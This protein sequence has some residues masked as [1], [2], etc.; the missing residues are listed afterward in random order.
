MT[1]IKWD[2]S[3]NEILTN[4]NDPDWYDYE[5][6]KWANAK[7][8]D[9]SYWVWIPRYAYKITSGYHSSETGTIDIK[10]LKGTSNETEDETK[11]E[12]S[13]YKVG[14]KDTSMHYF[15]HPAFEFNEAD[16]GFW[17]AKY[18]PTA[19]E[20]VASGV[21]EC[22]SLDNVTTKTVK[23][24]PNTTSWRCITIAKAYNVSFDMKNK[25]EIYGWL[26]AELDSH[27]IKNSEWG[28]VDYLSKSKYGAE[29][30]KI[31]NN[32]YNQYQTGCSG[33]GVNAADESICI[34]YNTENGVKAS[35][36]H[37]IYGIY[38]MSGGAYERIM[39]NY[40]NLPEWSGF[41]TTIIS[42]MNSKYINKYNTLTDNMLN[43]IGMD[44]DPNNYGDAVYETSNGA[45]RCDSYYCSTWVGNKY[46]SW[47]NNVSYLSH[48]YGPWAKRGGHFSY[49]PSA[50]LFSF[51]GSE[52]Y[53]IVS[54]TFRPVLF[55]E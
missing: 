3:N 17:V 11:I 13:G 15:L 4:E 55:A 38:D 27:V 18:E 44:Y 41:N 49:N 48:I 34:T 39:S 52:G 47:Y 36:T 16:L 8:Q 35:T 30:Q 6:K 21:E 45:A 40:N 28:A 31:W 7:S 9:G 53:D 29:D 2:E 26:P 10:F 19:T 46:G 51:T 32:A 20:G 1:P 14:V 42:N 24:E 54:C 33:S 50:G 23:I 37:N 25:T 43:N 22:N 12:T 5:N